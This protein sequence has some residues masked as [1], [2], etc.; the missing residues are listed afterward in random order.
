MAKSKGT[1]RAQKKTAG[2]PTAARAATRK[3][4]APAPLKSPKPGAKSK[5]KSR[6][7]SPKPRRLTKVDP[8]LFRALTEGE[9]ADALRILTEDKRLSSMAKVGR[10]RLIAAEPLAVKPPHPASGHRLARLVAYDY[11]SDRSVES[12][13]N[14]DESTVV[15]LSIGQSQPMLAREEEAATIA[16]A[17]AD[18]RVKSQLGLGDQAVAAMHYWSSREADIASRRRSAAVLFGQ[19][20]ARPRLV[21]VVDLIDNQVAAI[22]PAEQW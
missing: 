18:E 13:I 5:A 3:K 8:S 11:A 9:R 14:L 15:E 1:A 2:A 22:I 6:S 16:I 4:P 19:E 7:K 12:C 17:L 21:V 10:Y 20:G